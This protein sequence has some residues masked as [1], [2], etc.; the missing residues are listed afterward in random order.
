MI[1]DKNASYRC[2]T[3][4]RENGAGFHR[5]ICNGPPHW[6]LWLLLPTETSAGAEKCRMVH[7]NADLQ[8]TKPNENGTPIIEHFDLPVALASVPRNQIVPLECPHL[9]QNSK[10]TRREPQL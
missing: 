9:K 5:N 2:P 7:E 1:A 10:N 3:T 6:P 8:P 4:S